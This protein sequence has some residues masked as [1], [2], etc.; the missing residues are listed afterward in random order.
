MRDG[1]S[2]I[3]TTELA[4]LLAIP[5]PTGLCDAISNHVETR[6]SDMG[7]AV[8]RMRDGAVACVIEGTNRQADAIGFC[9]SP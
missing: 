5:S 9:R 3:I 1:L 7:L 4:A 6:L 2:D 8:R